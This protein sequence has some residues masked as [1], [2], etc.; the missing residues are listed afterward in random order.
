M[1]YGCKDKW[2]IT[3]LHPSNSP[4]FQSQPEVPP[5]QKINRGPTEGHTIQLKTLTTF[6]SFLFHGWYLHVK[7]VPLAW[8]RT[9]FTSLI[10]PYHK[11][12]KTLTCL[13]SVTQQNKNL[14]L[15]K[16]V[17]IVTLRTFECI[18]RCKNILSNF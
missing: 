13:H 14:I 3:P 17:T 10:M 4:N 8:Y 5:N 11:K 12:N 7:K 18:L 1:C 2:T 6:K 16:V 9:S 15:E